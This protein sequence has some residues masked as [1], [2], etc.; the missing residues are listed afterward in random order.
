MS[1]IL[2]ALKRADAERSRGA[3]PG[4]HARQLPGTGSAAPADS[5]NRV[6]WLMAGA[7]TLGAMAAGLW[8]WRTSAEV[9]R[10]P[11]PAPLVAAPVAV[12]TP[13]AAPAPVPSAPEPTAPMAP[14]APIAPTV[15]ALP[16][17]KQTARAASPKVSAPSSALPPQTTQAS[18]PPPAPAAIPLLSELPDAV[19]SQIPALKVTGTVYADD[20]KQRL[21]LVNNQVLPQGSLVAPE[22]TVEEIRPHSSVFNFRGTRFRL[23]H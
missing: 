2:D 15:P 20:P 23:A 1:Y 9:P 4:L 6:W 7:V 22:V 11:A 13:V 19:R 8:I 10:M 21:L 16:V 14:M 18:A 12:P 3:V 17:L 5:Q